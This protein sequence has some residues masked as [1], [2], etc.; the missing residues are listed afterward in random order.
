[1]GW[2]IEDKV[3]IK[4]M[5]KFFDDL[6]G[7]DFCQFEDI[8]IKYCIFVFGQFFVRMYDYNEWV[9][10]VGEVMVKDDR[11]G[12]DDSIIKES[13]NVEIVKKVSVEED[14]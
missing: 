8:E 5:I 7:F 3:W 1:M 2:I 10:N 13:V 9:K 11:D 14:V 12:E 6:F 4:R